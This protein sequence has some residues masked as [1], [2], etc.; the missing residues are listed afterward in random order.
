MGLKGLF[1]VLILAGCAAKDPDEQGKDLDQMAAEVKVVEEA[2]LT[3]N[4]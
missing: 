1:L 4:P 3:T 2:G